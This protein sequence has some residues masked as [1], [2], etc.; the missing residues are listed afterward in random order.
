MRALTSGF[1]LVLATLVSMT[2][3]ANDLGDAVDFAQK[4]FD[5]RVARDLEPQWEARSRHEALAMLSSRDVAADRPL[6]AYDCL[7][8]AIDTLPAVRSSGKEKA[9]LRECLKHRF[10]RP[11]LPGYETLGEIQLDA[12]YVKP[13]V[14]RWAGHY[15]VPE[16][17]VD[18]IMMFQSGYRP[19]AI[20]N[21]GHIGLMQLRPDLLAAQGIEHGD[22]MNPEENIRAG[23]AYLRKLYFKKGGLMK[24]LLVYDYGASDMYRDFRRRRWL[25]FAVIGIYKAG[26]R[27]FPNDLG[28][29]NM[30]FVWTWLE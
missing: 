23:A 9:A 4:H 24:A 22:L 1:A 29:E 13:L 27:N 3:R 16:T 30:T 15:E 17:V 19:H 8:S 2:A 14:A 20:S 5:R 28:A 18:A 25:A 26:N 7:D 11:S 6:F 21:D 12:V 10:E